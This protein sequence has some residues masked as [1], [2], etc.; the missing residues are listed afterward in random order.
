MALKEGKQTVKLKA[1]VADNIGIPKYPTTNI[2][3][4]ISKPI[5]ESIDA[6]R[7]VTEADASVQFKT[8]FNTKARDHY[9][10]LQS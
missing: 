1:S 5:A 7:K 9:I 8:D 10:E 2:A 3:T 4:E 6:F